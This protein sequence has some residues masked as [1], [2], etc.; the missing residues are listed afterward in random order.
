VA[1]HGPTKGSDVV[2][3]WTSRQSHSDAPCLRIEQR[4]VAEARWNLS[5]ELD[6]DN[7]S[8]TDGRPTPSSWSL[9]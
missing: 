3:D 6:A 7:A 9:A 5:G 4:M 2:I 8:S 1:L